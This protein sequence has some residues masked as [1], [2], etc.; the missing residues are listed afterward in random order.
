MWCTV[1]LLL[2][3]LGP[4]MN[5]DAVEAQT[6]PAGLRNVVRADSILCVDMYGWIFSSVQQHCCWWLTLTAWLP[7]AGKFE[8]NHRDCELLF[9]MHT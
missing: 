3:G 4:S 2:G 6:W 7:A 1:Y 5:V 9:Y 8:C